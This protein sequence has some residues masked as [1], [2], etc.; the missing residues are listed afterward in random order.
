M[1]FNGVHTKFIF[2][3]TKFI[4]TN[5]TCY[6]CLED[7]HQPWD[8]IGQF[9]IPL[10]PCCGR[11]I[12]VECIE[13]E[14]KYS[15]QCG[16]C[17]TEAP[18]EARDA[19]MQLKKNVREGRAWAMARLANLYLHGAVV[20]KNLWLAS[21]LSRRA[22][23]MLN[24]DEWDEKLADDARTTLIL[25]SI[26]NPTLIKNARQVVLALEP[27]AHAMGEH[28]MKY[29]TYEFFENFDTNQ[30]FDTKMVDAINNVGA[31]VCTDCTFHGKD[32]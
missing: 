6:I 13:Q 4:L 16:W 8:R 15:S 30:D 23:P 17:R 19:V 9:T 20:R 7:I 32:H 1:K 31:D 11:P 29:M 21:A 28:P 26:T 25:S 18:C 3:H 27:I 12:H 10:K 2:I 22:I 5:M 14:M 24:R